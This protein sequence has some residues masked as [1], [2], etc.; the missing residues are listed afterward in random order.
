MSLIDSRGW[1]LFL[2]CLHSV[3]NSL[4]SSYKILNVFAIY[5][6]KVNKIEV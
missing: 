1:E 2:A 3:V 5:Y 4:L 6:D